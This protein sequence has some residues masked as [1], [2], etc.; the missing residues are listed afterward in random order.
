MYPLNKVPQFDFNQP[1]HQSYDADTSARNIQP[2]YALQGRFIPPQQ[3]YPTEQVTITGSDGSN[4]GSTRSSDKDSPNET[5]IH[6][7][8]PHY[9]NT[10]TDPGPSPPADTGIKT[11]PN[12][13]AL[14]GAA[15]T[16]TTLAKTTQAS[17]TQTIPPNNPPRSTSSGGTQTSPEKATG[18]QQSQ[19]Y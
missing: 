2:Q 3:T 17:G 7:G 15:G 9:R 1:R 18:Q 8:F 10:G 14:V 4:E 16:Q 5:T 12:T 11:S 19:Q 13:P 6:N